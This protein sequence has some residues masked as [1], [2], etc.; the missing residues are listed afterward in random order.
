MVA[1]AE[2]PL[3]AAESWWEGKTARTTR[4]AAEVG[5]G[6]S[7]VSGTWGLS[8]SLSLVA[9]F[10][11]SQRAQQIVLRTHS[12]EERADRVGSLNVIE[13]QGTKASSL[14]TRIRGLVPT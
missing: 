9:A 5:G 2:A 12:G 4:G 6:D 3:S 10:C 13:S 8:L 7:L 14:W 11:C 1:P